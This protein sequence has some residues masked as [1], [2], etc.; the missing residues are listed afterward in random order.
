M[1]FTLLRYKLH[2]GCLYN[3]ADQYPATEIGKSALYLQ[4]IVEIDRQIYSP[5]LISS[6]LRSFY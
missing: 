1:S 6:I 3:L 2:S 5:A 4:Y